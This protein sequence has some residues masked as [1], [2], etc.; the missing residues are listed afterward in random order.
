LSEGRELYDQPHAAV[1][2]RLARFAE[3]HPTDSG[4]LAATWAPRT[5]GAP[6]SK[7]GAFTPS[8]KLVAQM[9][10][11]IKPEG[12]HTWDIGDVCRAWDWAAYGDAVIARFFMSG[13]TDLY[14]LSH[15]STHSTCLLD[16]SC[17]VFQ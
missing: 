3:M 10:A 4:T 16:A 1:P 15:P 2:L 11:Y 13:G 7:D 12:Q 9:H 5:Q 17:P 8:R 14:Y 6:G